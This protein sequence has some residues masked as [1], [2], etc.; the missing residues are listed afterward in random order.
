MSG[1]IPS[2]LSKTETPALTGLTKPVSWTKSDMQTWDRGV[3]N[4]PLS[5]RGWIIQEWILP[6]RTP[7][8]CRRGVFF[9]CCEGAACEHYFRGMPI[10]GRVKSPIHFKDLRLEGRGKLKS[11]SIEHWEAALG[12]KVYYY[13]AWTRIR[14]PYSSCSLTFATDK[15][16]A[17]SGICR[18][19][20]SHLLYNTYVAGVWLFNLASR[21]TWYCDSEEL[22]LRRAEDRDVSK[23]RIAWDIFGPVSANLVEVKVDGE[24]KSAKLVDIGTKTLVVWPLVVGYSR[25]YMDLS[26]GWDSYNP[27]FASARLDFAVSISDVSTFHERVFYYMP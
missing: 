25:K 26:D 24:L 23:G 19:L 8:F 12:Q 20:K 27:G 11:R 14:D 21:M 22:C 1:L 3:A 18:Y 10:F 7:H 13:N 17:I 16:V 5:S 4:A 6:A 9:E 15:L 2:V